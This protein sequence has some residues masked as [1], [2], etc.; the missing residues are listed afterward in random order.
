MA[1][2]KDDHEE[3]LTRVD[4]LLRKLNA[5]IADLREERRVASESM[6]KTS[7]D[8]TANSRRAK[9]AGQAAKERAD[10]RA[11]ATK[12]LTSRKRR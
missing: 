3:R 6:A 7:R 12:K 1:V 5:E 4:A 2:I 8:M 10:V 9:V 11:G